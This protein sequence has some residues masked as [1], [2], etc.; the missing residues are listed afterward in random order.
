MRGVAGGA[1]ETIIDMTRVLGEAGIR[2][3]LVRVVALRAKG[4]RPIYAEVRRG[5]KIGNELAGS[6][7][8]AE[9]VAALQDVR[10]S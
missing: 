2:H 6:G 3:N 7:S 9:F 1:G 8:L 10:P 5:K 4:K